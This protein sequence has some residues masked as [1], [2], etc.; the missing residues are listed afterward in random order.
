MKKEKNIEFKYKRLKNIRLLRY[1]KNGKEYRQSVVK[2]LLALEIIKEKCLDMCWIKNLVEWSDISAK[3]ACEIYNQD[4][5][6]TYQITIEEMEI[7]REVL[8]YNE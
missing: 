8:E 5:D 4:K 6:Y 2:K 3:D 7:L 1:P